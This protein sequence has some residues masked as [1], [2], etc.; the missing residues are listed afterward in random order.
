VLN[1]AGGCINSDAGLDESYSAPQ[2]FLQTSRFGAATIKQ[3]SSACCRSPSIGNP[4]SLD[5]GSF[6]RDV[7]RQATVD[8]EIFRQRCS[9][10]G[11]H[12][13]LRA[14]EKS[15]AFLG[16]FNGPRCIAIDRRSLR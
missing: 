10:R 3:L 11:W 1:R 9:Q 8:K 2:L 4:T 5:V 6:R 12:C 15:A 7:N 13:T 16:F 14:L